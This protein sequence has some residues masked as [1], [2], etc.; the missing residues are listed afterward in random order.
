MK[1]KPDG[2]IEERLIHRPQYKLN[3]ESLIGDGGI[4]SISERQRTLSNQSKDDGVFI[5]W[6]IVMFER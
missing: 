6:P 4:I 5:C 3:S 1:I 2:T